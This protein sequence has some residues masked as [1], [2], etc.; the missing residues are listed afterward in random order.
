MAVIED[1]AETEV[2]IQ[3]RIA[4]EKGIKINIS[5]IMGRYVILIYKIKM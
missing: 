1:V 5:Q 3:E 2:I 4:E